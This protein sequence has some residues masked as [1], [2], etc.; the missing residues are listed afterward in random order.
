[1]GMSP[2][3]LFIIVLVAAFWIGV[4]MLVARRLKKGRGA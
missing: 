2:L 4:A 3:Q 1:M